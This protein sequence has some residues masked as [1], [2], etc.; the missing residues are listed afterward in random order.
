MGEI[1]RDLPEGLRAIKDFK[2]AREQI[3][4]AAKKTDSPF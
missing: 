3:E 2:S 1:V 4:S